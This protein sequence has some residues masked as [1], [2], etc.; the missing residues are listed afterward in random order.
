MKRRTVLQ[1]IALFTGGLIIPLSSNSWVSKG[2]SKNPSQKKLI[3]VFLRGAI[4]GLNVVIPYQE[5]EYYNNRPNIAILP[6]NEPNGVLD[7]DGYF[8]LNP[9]LKDLMP[10]WK[11]KQL[12]FIHGCGLENEN[13][14][15]F[16]VQHYM[17]NG[18]PGNLKNDEGWMNR[19]LGI[20][21][22]K[23]PTQAV[24]IGSVTPEILRGSIPVANLPREKDNLQKLSTDIP[25]VNKLFNELYN[26][27][28]SLSLAYQEGQ[29]ARKI[30]IKEFENEMVESSK[31]APST[32]NFVQ[33]VKKMAKL[34][35]GEANTQLGFIDLGQWDTHINQSA[36]LNRLLMPLG[37]GLATLALELGNLFNDT[38]ILVMSEFGRT[39]KEN[40]NK[41]TDHGSGNLMWILGGNIKGG[42]FYGQWNTLEKKALFEGRD[43]PITTDF[44][45]PISNIL[46]T[47][48][49]LSPQLINQVFP[50]F[51]S[52]NSLNFISV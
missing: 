49:D 19:L 33:E 45:Q 15:H 47:N 24:N 30:F 38:T 7:L 6:P 51:N 12:T 40:G 48:F 41:G 44:R 29:K 25:I 37:E 1:Q 34:M 14:S 13:R 18:T 36:Q 46:S 8:G 22:S 27:N 11:K 2:L 23:N 35:S 9:A 17:E 31:N 20:L 16:E 42:K 5:D 3:V 52:K 39:V 43:I 32:S 4:D 10:L 21:S 26:G 28:D 50:N